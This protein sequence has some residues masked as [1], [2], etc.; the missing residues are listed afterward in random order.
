MVVGPDRLIVR[1]FNIAAGY[2][3][4]D[5]RPAR[6][7]PAVFGQEGPV[8][9]GPDRN[10]LWAPNGSV[11]QT[12]MRLIGYDGRPTGVSIP[13]P[14]GGQAGSDERDTS[15]STEPVACIRRVRA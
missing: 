9:P 5:G 10:H 7:L 2:Q 11:S 3:V 15:R 6:D 1:P 12:A 8:L 13:V 4:R 14:D